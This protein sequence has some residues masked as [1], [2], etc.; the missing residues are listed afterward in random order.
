MEQHVKYRYPGVNYFKREDR[1]V[2]CGREQDTQNLYTQIMLSKTVV[3]HG[4]SGTGK[5]SLL[6]AGLLPLLEEKDPEYMPVLIRFDEYN[7]YGKA[8][9]GED[10]RVDS[11][12]LQTIDKIRAHEQSFSE[13][14]LPFIEKKTC[15][16]WYEV[17]LAEY[18]KR[19]I[20][21]IFD[22]FEEIQGYSNSEIDCFVR[23]LAG[24]FRSEVPADM[25]NE[26][27]ENMSRAMDKPGF[28]DK[29]RAVLNRGI[30][31]MESPLR[32]KMMFVVREDKLG[33]MSLLSDYFPDIL[34]N[35]FLLKQL[36]VE[37]A[38]KAILDPAEKDGDY[39]SEKF[40]F[41]NVDPLLKSITEPNTNLVDPLQIQ[42]I[43]SNI[44]RT[45]AKEKRLI[46]E[47]DIPTISAVINS[48]YANCWAEVKKQL[49]LST[50]AFDT[51]RRRYIREIIVNEKRKLVFK[52]DLAIA[53]FAA[54]T[55]QILKVLCST[56]LLRVVPSGKDPYYQLC[57]DR[58]IKPMSDDLVQLNAKKAQALRTAKRLNT[59][60]TIA[61]IIIG[62]IIL[63]GTLVYNQQQ[64]RFA[65]LENI[66]RENEA[67]AAHEREL[68][69]LQV[70]LTKDSLESYTEQLAV[71]REMAE[72]KRMKD[73]ALIHGESM[74]RQA[75]LN[76]QK[77]QYDRL[78]LKMRLDST[79]SERDKAEKENFRR[80]AAE[81]TRIKD[82]MQK[83]LIASDIARLSQ[84]SKTNF[85]QKIYAWLAYDTL[86][87]MAR[88]E[89][90]HP[91]VYGALANSL[92]ESLSVRSPR[93]TGLSGRRRYVNIEK[94]YFTKGDFYYSVPFEGI[95]NNSNSLW[96]DSTMVRSWMDTKGTFIASVNIYSKEK[97]VFVVRNASTK[98]TIATLSLGTY[99][100]IESVV[101]DPG[102]GSCIYSTV[103]YDSKQPGKVG[104]IRPGCRNFTEIQSPLQKGEF[105][106]LAFENGLSGVTNNGKFY[107]WDANY[108]NVKMEKALSVSDKLQHLNSVS[109]LQRQG[110]NIYIGDEFGNIY[111]SDAAGM[112]SRVIGS[113]GARVTALAVTDN[114]MWLSAAFANGTIV[115]WRL[116]SPR[117]IPS[118]LAGNVACAYTKGTGRFIS[119]SFSQDDKNLLAM[120]DNGVV[121]SFP[122][123]M[124]ALAQKICEQ[125]DELNDVAARRRNNVPAKIKNV[126]EKK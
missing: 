20:L 10:S 70:K 59:I 41:E 37:N 94:M 54:L 111:M 81:A 121:Y 46:K 69:A 115:L 103:T 31:F 110:G 30:G 64:R 14:E 106:Y 61:A 78:A 19:T 13:K 56:G 98:D 33:V 28:S 22:Q 102:T 63:S 5:S 6:Q 96:S 66:N 50:A 48:F 114:N 42:I 80:S 120:N 7:K 67:K 93:K 85:E 112:Q 77:N 17:K 92:I 60:R 124:T 24:L 62:V 49:S 29:D 75:E 21:F 90:Y 55:D 99:E 109:C 57:H 123:S 88:A 12:V 108:T 72:L 15:N 11:L 118:F 43:C 38:K 100:D 26:M 47:S 2:F 25:Y 82:S 125:Q 71:N 39:F 119:L 45:V 51:I 97:K 79:M 113:E 68:A 76:A 73:S 16:L 74:R 89:S 27:Q 84:Q 32:V 86:P 65:R 52:D 126:C 91:N 87:A 1:D 34:K 104:Y 83:I 117:P 105:L 3:V 53:E 44:E 101:F 35:S 40:Q 116:N 18:N 8:G 36:T 4:D 9:E 122:L 95:R 23:Q 107:R 58:L